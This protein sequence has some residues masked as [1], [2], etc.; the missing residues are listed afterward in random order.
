MFLEIVKT[1]ILQT[2]TSESEKELDLRKKKVRLK[3]ANNR[4][5]NNNAFVDA[6]NNAE[7][8]IPLKLR[9]KRAKYP[10]YSDSD[11]SREK[12]EK[13]EDINFSPTE[14]IVKLKPSISRK[15]RD[16][17]TEDQNA[18]QDILAE[19]DVL[20]SD[21]NRKVSQ[22]RLEKEEDN[23]F[24]PTENIV[25]LKPSISRKRRDGNTEDQNAFQDIL[26]EDDV[27]NSDSNREVSQESLQKEDDNFSP[28]ENVMKLK[29]SISRK[30]R[31]GNTE[32]RNAFQDMLTE[33]DV[34]NSDLDGEVSQER[35]QREEDNFSP[36]ENIVKLKQSISRKRRDGSTE[37]RN[38]FQAI[39]TKDDVLNSS[40]GK[41]SVALEK[42][43][44]KRLMHQNIDANRDHTNRRKS[45]KMSQATPLESTE[46]SSLNLLIPNVENAVFENEANEVVQSS[47]DSDIKIIHNKRLKLKSRFIL[48]ARK[49]IGKNI[50]ADAL[51][52]NSSTNSSNPNKENDVHKSPIR[53][54]RSSLISSKRSVN[55]SKTKTDI[56]HE[57]SPIRK[58]PRSSLNAAKKQLSLDV[59]TQAEDNIETNSS[60]SSLDNNESRR[61]K[62]SVFLKPKSRILEN[63]RKSIINNPFEEIFKEGG[64]ISAKKSNVSIE[65]NRASLKRGK[66]TTRISQIHGS[67]T[68]EKSPQLERNRTTSEEDSDDISLKVSSNVE[69]SVSNEFDV[70]ENKNKLSENSDLTNASK[71][72]SRKN[73]I[74]TPEKQISPSHKSIR[75]KKKHTHAILPDDRTNANE[76]VTYEIISDDVRDDTNI[77]QDLN[78]SKRASNSNSDKEARL[79][80]NSLRN[81]FETLKPAEIGIP[82]VIDN[83]Y[84]DA[85][86]EH[87]PSILKRVSQLSP[88][89][90]V[91][92]ARSLRNRSETPK[93]V[94][95]EVREVTDNLRDDA[96]RKHD[97]NIPKR[98]SKS[99]PGK[100]ARLMRNSL[101]NRSETP[102]SVNIEIHEVTDNSRDD[103]NNESDSSTPKRV[104]KSSPAKEARLTR[105][106]LRNRSET[107][108][109]A[110]IEV[111]IDNSRDNA[112]REYDSSTSKRV[113][114]SSPGKEARL[115]RNNLKNRSETPKLTNKDMELS[116]RNLTRIVDIEEVDNVNADSEINI[117]RVSQIMSSTKISRV[118][119]NVGTHKSIILS[120][121]T[122]TIDANPAR[123]T[124]TR[125]SPSTKAE[126]NNKAVNQQSVQSSNRTIKDGGEITRGVFSQKSLNKS[127][128]YR[129]TPIESSSKNISLNKQNS[130]NTQRKINDFFVAK[131]APTMMERSK[132]H[133]QKSQIFNE[134]MEKIKME[135]EKIKNREMAA[136]KIVTADKKES[137]L[138]AKNVKSLIPK[139]TT[140]KKPLANP[141][142]VVD[143]A[144]LVNGKVYKAP[145]LPRPKYWATNRLYKFLWNRME[146]KYKLATRVKSEKFVQELAKI[147]SFVERRKN[148]ENYKNEMEAL[149]KEMARLKIINTRN[150]FYHF[151]QDFLP[152]EFRVKVVPMLLPGNISNIPYDPEKVHLPLLDNN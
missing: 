84:N 148:Y 99:S 16:G 147:V 8:S 137:A 22:E 118:N 85:N 15:R 67:L 69:K 93:P 75:E 123:Q 62:R 140:K 117:N 60:S 41:K 28:T 74:K 134:K 59:P 131:Q 89:K 106:N 58:S 136:M 29:P 119:A 35:L 139:Q 120:T 10:I 77:E 138:K 102:K 91:R 107:S 55:R 114:K 64:N 103:A 39:L 26:A 72:V 127:H 73:V 143:K 23:N 2:S 70:S 27:L 24:S 45:M 44:S 125:N 149:M 38:V 46:T 110:N 30:R 108:K 37:D 81:Q 5:S 124:I 53:A 116:K 122:D 141:A 78:T 82:D 19:D 145:R 52:D 146:P 97:S 32:D 57:S 126:T 48:R 51:T 88:S 90:E 7:V 43:S 142:K 11:I 36:T 31:D 121:E 95:T 42:E 76:I 104:S 40:T 17:R 34:L 63:L 6:L 96:N 47:D 61:M 79:T 130:S 4:K 128:N 54:S 3:G 65:D 115:T 50:F 56:T 83:L 94:N 112:N 80:R 13:E 25:K 109:S 135:L 113:S 105:N 152:Y 12:L 68:T 21:S 144:F 150:D 87:D 9:M 101:R 14:N 98:V 86:R 20:N 66:T 18:F 133:A 33:D 151:C 49:S 71:S 111:H 129:N 100:E 92:L 1:N 132:E